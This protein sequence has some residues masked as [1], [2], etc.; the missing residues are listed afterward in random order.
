[1]AVEEQIFRDLQKHLNEGPVGYPATESG[2][3]IRF[4]KH[5]FTSEEARIHCIFLMLSWSQ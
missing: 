2:A 4:L 5:F 3:D 1:M